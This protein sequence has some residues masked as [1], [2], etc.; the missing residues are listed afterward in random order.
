MFSRREKKIR[1]ASGPERYTLKVQTIVGNN[2]REIRRQLDM[3]CHG[4]IVD[5]FDIYCLPA[6]TSDTMTGRER[7]IAVVTVRDYNVPCGTQLSKGVFPVVMIEKDNLDSVVGKVNDWSE[8]NKNTCLLTRISIRM[9]P[10]NGGTS[11]MA[12]ATYRGV[13]GRV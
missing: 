11:W 13:E 8:K 1:P 6:R 9:F 7:W 4:S 12:Y 2:I 10:E 5:D 3:L